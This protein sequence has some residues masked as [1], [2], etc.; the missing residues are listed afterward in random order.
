M[1]VFER[2]DRDTQE[3][4]GCHGG[5][6]RYSVNTVLESPPGSAFKYVRDLSLAPGSS[7][8]L[9]RHDRDEEMYYV[10][11]GIGLVSCERRHEETVGEG[12]LILTQLGGSHSLRNTGKT[13]LRILVVCVH[14][15]MGGGQ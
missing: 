13:P 12:A 4:L 7:I 9:H 10:L 1:P 15:L 2:R 14:S 5:E 6:G 8:G 3:L 11:S